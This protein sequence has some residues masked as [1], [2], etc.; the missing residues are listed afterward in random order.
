MDMLKENC[1]ITHINLSGNTLG[2]P[3]AYGIQEML[4]NNSTVTHCYLSGRPLILTA[5]VGHSTLGVAFDDKAAEPISETM[6][7]PL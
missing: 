6:K 7:V 1:Y 5:Q 2:T 3:G 4:Q